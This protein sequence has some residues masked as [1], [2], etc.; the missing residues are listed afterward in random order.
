MSVSLPQDI[1][2]KTSTDSQ[3]TSERSLSG[4]IPDGSFRELLQVL[5]IDEKAEEEK[6]MTDKSLCSQTPL[7]P[8]QGQ[9]K[10]KIEGVEVPF[11]PLLVFMTPGLSSFVS[12]QRALP[13]GVEA[14]FEKMASCMIV[15][16]SSNEVETTLVLDN[17]SSIFFGTKITIREFSSA[18]K[19]FNVEIASFAQTIHM[20]ESNKIDLLSAFQNGNFNFSIH[21][22]ETHIQNEDRPVLHRKESG[23]RDNQERRG[24][25]EQ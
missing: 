16:S 19:A 17:P 22:F 12:T 21:R 24:G 13:P 18:P 2:R 10:E 9:K 25:R 15:M 23:D 1:F 5:P 6:N 3:K 20:I 7:P 8:L 11:N 4:E 14:I